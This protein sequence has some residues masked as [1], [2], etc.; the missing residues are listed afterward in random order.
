MQELP[1]LLI[2]L[3]VRH[4][5]MNVPW[6][7]TEMRLCLKSKTSLLHWWL[8]VLAISMLKLSISRLGNNSSHRVPVLLNKPMCGTLQTAVACEPYIPQHLPSL[9]NFNLPRDGID[10]NG[11]SI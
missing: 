7:S 5:V 9:Q 10:D 11:L 3:H 8:H 1:F 4:R 2:I 6:L